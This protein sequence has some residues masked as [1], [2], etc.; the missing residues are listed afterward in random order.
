MRGMAF[1]A[2]GPCF[3]LLV[4]LPPQGMRPAAA[5]CCPGSGG[6]GVGFLQEE[7]V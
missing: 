6:C 1:R 2:F 5:L 4:H 7:L 3:Q